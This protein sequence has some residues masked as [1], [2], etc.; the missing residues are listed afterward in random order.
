MVPAHGGL[1]STTEGNTVLQLLCN[2]LCNQLSISVR[3]LDLFDVYKQLLRS[4]LLNFCLQLLNLRT[5]L[6]DNYAWLSSVDD[7]LYTV[8]CALNF[9]LGNTGIL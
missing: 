5:A 7:N 6:T 1:H 8:R 2:R 4:H 3:S 9:D